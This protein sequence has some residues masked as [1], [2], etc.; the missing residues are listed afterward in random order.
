MSLKSRRSRYDSSRGR[1]RGGAERRRTAT[2]S[3]S[4]RTARLAAQL[5]HSPL[6]GGE[7]Q[8]AVSI[9]GKEAIYVDD[10]RRLPEEERDEWEPADDEAVYYTRK[11]W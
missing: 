3:P 4:E 9:R 10:W 11:P 7:D 8:I 1:R 5:R 2:L 6:P